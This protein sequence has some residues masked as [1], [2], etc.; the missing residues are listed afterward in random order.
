MRRPT[1]P[2]RGSNVDLV[3]VSSSRVR[4]RSSSRSTAAWCG[5][6]FCRPG[7]GGVQVDL[8]LVQRRCTAG[9]GRICGCRDRSHVGHAQETQPK[10][11]LARSGCE[12]V[13]V[14][15]IPPLPSPTTSPPR[16]W[17]LPRC[18]GWR[19]RRGRHPPYGGWNAGI[20]RANSEGG[21]G[22]SPAL[23]CS[24]CAAT[25]SRRRRRICSHSSSPHASDRATETAARAKSTDGSKRA[26]GAQSP[27]ITPTSPPPPWTARYRG[28]LGAPGWPRDGD[29]RR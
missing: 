24:P 17:G 18:V 26:V 10:V 23:A 7:C 9:S 3:L 2:R 20:V 5:Q 11:G 1:R 14:G 19:I 13:R 4:R 8:V 29:S 22:T 6:A 16:T 21:I 27:P 12:D 15:G 28:T 25:A